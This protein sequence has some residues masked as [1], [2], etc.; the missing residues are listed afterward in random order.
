MWAGTDAHT[1]VRMEAV[2]LIVAIETR[3]VCDSQLSFPT[4]SLARRLTDPQ[5]TF[6]FSR[7]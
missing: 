6:R 7:D 3:P 4:N 5:L 1:R 2:Y